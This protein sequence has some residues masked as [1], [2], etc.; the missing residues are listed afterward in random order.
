MGREPV[1]EGP[2]SREHQKVQSKA[3][4]IIKTIAHLL[5]IILRPNSI[6]HYS[7]NSLFGPIYGAFQG[8]LPELSIELERVQRLLQDFSIGNVDQ[9][10]LY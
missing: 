4:A 9:Y 8:M 6:K 7:T 1:F 5:N 10:L 2:L 3:A